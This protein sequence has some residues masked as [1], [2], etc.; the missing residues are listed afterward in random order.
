VL[1]VGR[2]TR[3][4]GIIHLVQA[5]PYI[6]AG[7]QI[8][9]CAGAPDTEA[10]AHEMSA[11]VERARASTA[12]AIIWIPE[13]VPPERLVVLYSHAELFVCPS[14]YEPFGITNLEAMA[15][16]TPVVAA[17]VGGIPEVVVQGR[18]GILVPFEPVSDAD[19][20]PRRPE[21]Y[22]RDLAAAVNQ[23]L[24]APERRQAMGAE[25][26]RRV[27]AHFGWEAIARQ[28]V[29]YYEELRRTWSQRHKLI[30]A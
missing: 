28:T 11:E 1:F 19:P 20:E 22:A 9:L 25:A 5:L 21:Q 29:Q 13:M 2:I 27:E 26:R 7:V 17:A 14:I 6:E 23:L 15:C 16:S 4:K 12:N 30:G 10:L 24:Y 18:T 8:V 3:Q